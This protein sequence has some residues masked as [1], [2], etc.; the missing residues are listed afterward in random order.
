MSMKVLLYTEVVTYNRAL[1]TINPYIVFTK[2]SLIIRVRRCH[3]RLLF[4]KMLLNLC[5]V[6]YDNAFPF[7]DLHIKFSLCGLLGIDELEYLLRLSN[8]GL[9]LICSNLDKTL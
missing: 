6:S 3:F 8:N 5:I 7:T 9:I 1:G 4:A 2:G